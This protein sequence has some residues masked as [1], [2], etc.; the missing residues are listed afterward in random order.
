MIKLLFIVGLRRSGTSILRNL[1]IRHMMIND[2]E[3]EPHDLW[4]AIDLNHFK[5]MMDKPDNRQWVTNKI[6]AFGD[7]GKRGKYHGAKFA[8][9]P[10][11]K[12]LEWVWLKKTFPKAKFIFIVRDLNNTWKSVYKQDRDSVR[13]IID[14]KAYDIMA[15][16]LVI[17]FMKSDS[18][19]VRYEN[20]VANADKELLKVW[21]YL[22]LNEIAGLNQMMKKPENWSG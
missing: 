17:D 13:G 3:F 4:A 21:N 6:K 1:L 18:P 8:L 10:G 22:G 7:K 14:K 15:T 5:R 12:A 20:L 16:D 2:I 9:N 11:T 19:V